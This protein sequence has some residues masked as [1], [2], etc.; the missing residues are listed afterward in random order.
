VSRMSKTKG[1]VG[2]REVASLLREYG[3]DAKRGVQ[4]AGGTDSPDVVHSIPDVHIEVKRTERLNLQ[5]AFEQS[6]GDAGPGKTPTVFHRSSRQPWLV[7]LT[8]RDFLKYMK[9]FNEYQY[10]QKQIDLVNAS[11]GSTGRR[12][13]GAAPSST[14]SEGRSGDSA[15]GVDPR[16]FETFYDTPTR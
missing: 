12:V 9:A 10:I 16:T 15:T 6:V 14:E 11:A 3:F 7:T 8:A 13:E 2:E 4:Y 5:A 1:K